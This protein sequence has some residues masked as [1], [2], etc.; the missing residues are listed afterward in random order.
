MVAKKI[1]DAYDSVRGRPIY[2]ADIVQATALRVKA[3]R[4]E[5]P[6]ALI[7]RVDVS[8]AV[9]T[10]GVAAVLTAGDIPGQNITGAV[11]LDRPLL[12]TGKVRS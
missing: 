4:S 10:P 6:H 3:L 7:R 1:Y 2:T 9:N 12:A 8:A 5:Y 11:V